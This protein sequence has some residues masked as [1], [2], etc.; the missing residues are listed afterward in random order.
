MAPLSAKKLKIK[1]VIKYSK[2]I[3]VTLGNETSTTN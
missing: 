1:L 3:L 2:K